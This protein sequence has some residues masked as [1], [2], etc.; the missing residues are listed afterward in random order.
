[1]KVSGAMKEF[2]LSPEKEAELFARAN[3]IL[4]TRKELFQKRQNKWNRISEFFSLKEFNLE[5]KI[6]PLLIPATAA[7]IIL[8]LS[9][10]PIEYENNFIELGTSVLDHQEIQGE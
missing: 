4:D 7:I 6:A 3:S 1:M 10:D 8:L 9:A 2:K 5:L